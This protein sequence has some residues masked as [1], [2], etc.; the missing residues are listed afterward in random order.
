MVF[1]TFFKMGPGFIKFKK[2][3]DASNFKIGKF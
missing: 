1:Y 2:K 3:I